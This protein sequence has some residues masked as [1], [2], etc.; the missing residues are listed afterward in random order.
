[1]KERISATIEPQT[2]KMLDSV[3]KSGRYRNLSHIIEDAIKSIW[4]KTNEK[5]KK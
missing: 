1:M 3:M 2:K 5:A 4:E